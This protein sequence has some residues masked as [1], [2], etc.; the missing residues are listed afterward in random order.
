MPEFPVDIL[1]REQ[2][3]NICHPVISVL[4]A[5]YIN[6]TKV[7][8]FSVRTFSR[9]TTSSILH[10]EQLHVASMILNITDKIVFKCTAGSAWYADPSLDDLHSSA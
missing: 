1:H 3:N 5:E 9:Y 4:Y 8:S 6:M 2:E 10:V 7:I